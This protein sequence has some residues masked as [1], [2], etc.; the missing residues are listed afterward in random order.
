[1]NVLVI[2][3]AVSSKALCESTNADYDEYEYSDDDV[4]NIQ[5]NN[6][7]GSRLV[8]ARESSTQRFPFLVGWN[9][10]G[11]NNMFSCT[12]SLLTQKYVLSAAHCNN[13]LEQRNG[14]EEDRERC[15]Q[16]TASGQWYEKGVRKIKCRWLDSKGYSA[17]DLEV[18][19]KPPSKAWVGIN[20]V[21]M[22][23]QKNQANMYEI[24][25][26]IRHGQSY[27]G[28]GSYGSYGGYD[29]TLLEL[30][31]PVIGYRPACLPGPKFDDIRLMEK[32]TILA[33]YGKYLRT[34]GE[35]CQ[36]NKFGP[37]KKHYCDK[38]YGVGN[39]ACIKDQPAP[40]HKECFKF[41]KNPNTPNHFQGKEIRITG[42]NGK[43]ITICYPAM[44]LEDKSYGWCRTKGNYYNVDRE[45][46]ELE[47]WGFCGK[48]CFLDAENSEDTGVLRDKENIEILSED[49]CDKYLNISLN[50]QKVE[51]RPQILC[52]AENNKWKEEHW[53][54]TDGGYKRMQD[55]GPATRFGS[56]SY[57]ASVGTCQ[58]DS[59]GPAFVRDGYNYVVTGV[60]SGGRGTL[61]ECGGINNPVHYVR[62][63]KLVMWIM[64][65]LGKDKR[66]VCWDREFEDKRKQLGKMKNIF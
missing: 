66:E 13:M 35:T 5:K 12:G 10:Y 22:N 8:G 48:D 41:F 38:D 37:M 30:A 39:A 40:N 6:G 57:V 64:R 49:L 43:D 51:V 46:T 53:Q 45:D 44:N 27:R 9:Q 65:N 33:G 50:W 16:T 26:H 21:K 56:S 11:A 3:V 15:V 1:M 4:G 52:V 24:K 28:G 31:R 47:S 19:T 42:K 20:K 61:G 34:K 29:I 17:P 58:G 2:L 59:G 32:N 62:V 54:K 25:R 63:K 60:V 55:R 18:I 23:K 36:T 14:R 7:D